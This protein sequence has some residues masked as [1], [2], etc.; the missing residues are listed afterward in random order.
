[1]SA[2]RLEA[3]APSC[4][5]SNFSAPSG[6]AKRSLLA[7]FVRPG[8]EILLRVAGWPKVQRVLQSIDAVEQSGINAADV[9]PDHSRHVH[10]RL[11]A[12]EAPRPYSR[13]QHRTWMLRKRTVA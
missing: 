10:N 9:C 8:G 4:H 11:A 12:G 6:R 2:G 7:P 1:M 5:A 3:S 13:D